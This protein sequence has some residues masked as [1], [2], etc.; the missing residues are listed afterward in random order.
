MDGEHLLYNPSTFAAFYSEHRSSGGKD[1][2]PLE[3]QRGRKSSPIA[4]REDMSIAP[5]RAALLKRAEQEPP[6]HPFE[7]RASS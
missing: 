1:T 4:R 5:V 2:V 7:D 6:D 3:K